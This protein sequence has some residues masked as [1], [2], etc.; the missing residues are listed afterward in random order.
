MAQSEPTI[1]IIGGGIGGLSAALSLLDAGLDVQVYER[2]R[3]ISEIGAGIAVSP[4]ATRILHRLGLAQALESTAVK[5]LAWHDRRWDDGRTLLRSPLA[6]VME[7][8]FGFPLYHMHRA[9]L[10]GA[11]LTP[12]PV[13]LS[14]VPALRD[15]PEADDLEAHPPVATIPSTS[16]P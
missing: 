11:L 5:T 3:T 2:A 12:L 4:N 13:L 9:D 14:R 15:M 6:G 10:V 8:A 16:A 7:T 1:A